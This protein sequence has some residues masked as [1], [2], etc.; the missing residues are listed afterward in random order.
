MAFVVSFLRRLTRCQSKHLATNVIV[1]GGCY[2]ILHWL[3]RPSM[4]CAADRELVQV[5]YDVHTCMSSVQSQ[6]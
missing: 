1:V 4:N 2:S 6:F 3:V 5:A